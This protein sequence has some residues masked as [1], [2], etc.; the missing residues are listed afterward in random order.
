MKILNIQNKIFLFSLFLL[1]LITLGAD[2]DGDKGNSLR[3]KKTTSDFFVFNINNLFI[4][5]D[6][7]G[8]IGDVDPGPG[9]GAGGKFDGKVFLFS[10]GFYVSGLQNGNLWSNGVLSA[11]RIED[12]Q[13]GP[14]GSSQNDA[15]NKVY[16]VSVQDPAFGDSWQE[17]KDAV[18]IGADYFDGDLNGTYDPVDLNGNGSWDPD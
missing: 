4:P 6:N 18:S 11:S 15:K 7:K 13:A 14:V 5:L 16:A 12:Y 2:V 10:G 3:L 8:V 17:W 9:I 1:A